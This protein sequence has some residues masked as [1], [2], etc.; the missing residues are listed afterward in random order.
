[1]ND[2]GAA[3]T[4]LPQSLG[5]LA[6]STALGL[7]CWLFE[8]GHVMRARRWLHEQKERRLVSEHGHIHSRL[9]QSSRHRRLTTFAN[10]ARAPFFVNGMHPG[11]FPFARLDRRRSGLSYNELSPRPRPSGLQSSRTGTQPGVE[12]G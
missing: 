11:D 2:F 12:P 8:D 10:L 9:S 3:G 5:H 1:M 6:F 4:L 7:E